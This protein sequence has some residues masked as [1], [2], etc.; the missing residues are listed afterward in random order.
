MPVTL[1]AGISVV[2]RK[3]SLSRVGK[4]REAIARDVGDIVSEDHDLLV[5]GP[6]FEAE[7]PSGR[8]KA[9]GLEYYDDF[10]DLP[11]TGGEVPEWCQ[12]WLSLRHD[13][14]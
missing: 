12:I 2:V 6:C 1:G 8:L 13:A 7:T 14:R 4:D 9:L 10:F 3:S 5:V 11:N